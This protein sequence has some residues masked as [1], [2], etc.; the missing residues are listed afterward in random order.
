MT[1]VALA[2]APVEADEVIL[3]VGSWSLEETADQQQ[4]QQQ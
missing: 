3:P 2:D 1:H 4:Q